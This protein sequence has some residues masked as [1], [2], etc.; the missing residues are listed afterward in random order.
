[1]DGR[2]VLHL[3]RRE[4]TTT[5]EWDQE[6]GKA[7]EK[8]RRGNIL[9]SPDLTLMS[10]Q[11]ANLVRMNQQSYVADFNVEGDQY[12]P[13]VEILSFGTVLDVEA[14]ASANR[15]WITLTLRPTSTEVLNWR[16]FGGDLQDFGGI[17]VVNTSTDGDDLGAIA[18]QFPLMIP[19]MR[20]RAVRTSVTIPDGGS[21]LIAGFTSAQ[22]A[23]SH[24]GIPF[25]SHIPF[26][27]RLF[28]RLCSLGR[29]TQAA[30]GIAPRRRAFA[31]SSRGESA[32]G[33]APCSGSGYRL[34]F[35]CCSCFGLTPLVAARGVGDLVS[36]NA[37]PLAE[38]RA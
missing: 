10:G 29:N 19:E 33:F 24:S 2:S 5:F 25:L 9:I 13:I 23:R 27:G 37:P 16:R 36:G 31:R 21:L 22:S 3:T 32:H 4:Q 14:I 35:P 38:A 15:Q 6:S 30:P 26:L 20:Y 12:D 18:G 34:C 17:A 8:T 11:R 28:S 7:V 1:M